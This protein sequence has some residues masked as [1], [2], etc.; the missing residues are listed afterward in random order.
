MRK[1]WIRSLHTA[2]GLFVIIPLLSFTLTGVLL[3]HKHEL[4]L[5]QRFIKSEW[6]MRQ[7]GLNLSATPVTWNLGKNDFFTEYTGQYILNGK[8]IELDDTPLSAIKISSG[9]CIASARKIYFFDPRCLLIE[10]LE[11]G[12]SLPEGVI[13]KLGTSHSKQL[14]IQYKNNDKNGDTSADTYSYHTA[15]SPELMSF[16]PAKASD[17]EYW[18][19]QGDISS[20]HLRQAKKAIIACGQPLERVILDFHSG[21]IFSL[22][23]KI[24]V[25]L[26]A[27]G[28]LGLSISGLLIAK[29]KRRK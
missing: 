2:L 19:E 22:A 5:N 3:N 24:L 23:G 17:A 9:F 20:E 25:D 13:Q 26:F 8:A 16:T 11:V 18:A 27:I 6:I 21:N 4:G 1:K 28:V 15:Q 14:I 12:L 29:R 7:Y 10:E